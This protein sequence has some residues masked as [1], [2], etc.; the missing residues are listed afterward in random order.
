MKVKC[1]VKGEEPFLVY[2][3]VYDVLTGYPEGRVFVLD[4]EELT[5]ELHPGEY[6]IVDHE[7]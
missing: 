4:T 7:D 5:N 1:L 2:G 6:E 3:K